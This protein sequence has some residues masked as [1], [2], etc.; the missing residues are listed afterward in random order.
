MTDENTSNNTTLE[1][2]A[3]Q[4]EVKTKQEPSQAQVETPKTYTE[5]EF[6]NAMAA[7]R[8]RTEDKVLRKYSDVD[9]SKYHELIAQEEQK[10]LDEQ[11]AKGEFEKIL[12]EQ[13]DKAN[14]KIQ[15]LHSELT[16]IKVDGALLNAASQ[17]KAI[18]PDQVTRL[19]RDQV[20]M[21]ETGQ[22]EVID[23]VSGQTRYTESGDP[24][25][26][27]QLVDEFLKNSPHF[28]QAGPAG[29][30]SQSSVS[31]NAVDGV[32]PMKLDMNNPE[33]RKIYA[34]YRKKQGIA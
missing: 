18:N 3:T 1:T 9:V 8:S 25:S 34:E 31:A 17:K 23:P 10:K 27:V 4:E 26:P 13:A 2:T 29:G 12:K 14:S 20:R 22:V 11:K 21:S 32:D 28:V 5:E 7:V 16:K 30:G 33:H 24:L 15:S 6:K 19:V